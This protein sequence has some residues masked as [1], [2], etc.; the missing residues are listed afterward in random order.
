MK[1]GFYL[2][3]VE[4]TIGQGDDQTRLVKHVIAQ[5]DEPTVKAD[6]SLYVDDPKLW[7]T[8][9]QPGVLEVLPA[10]TPIT[11]EFDVKTKKRND[12]TKYYDPVPVEI[13]PVRSA[14]TTS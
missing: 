14:K 1:K 13:K 3:G 12:G 4:Q 6:G 7:I 5:V 2:Q 11:F 9:L 10:G 8:Y